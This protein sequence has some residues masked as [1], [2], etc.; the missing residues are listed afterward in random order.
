M[1]PCWFAMLALLHDKQQ[2]TV[3][4][5]ADYFGITQ[6][7]VSQVTRDLED[8]GWMAVHFDTRKRPLQLT[9]IERPQ[10]EELQLT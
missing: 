8:K 5:G 2:V 6:P 10:V 4:E 1:Q 7:A 9:A 3:M